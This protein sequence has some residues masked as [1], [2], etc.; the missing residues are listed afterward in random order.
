M[1]RSVL[2]ALAALTI[3]PL[4]SVSARAN[5]CYDQ[6]GCVSTQF[7]SK[8]ALYPMSCQLLWNVRNQ[9]Y[10]DRGY[11]FKTATGIN[12]MGNDGCYINNQSAVPLNDFERVNVLKIRS[13]ENAKGCNYGG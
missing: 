1:R 13:V 10:K 8:S 6:V 5:Q 9:I 2:A 12:E 3:I 7:I 11:C 4:V